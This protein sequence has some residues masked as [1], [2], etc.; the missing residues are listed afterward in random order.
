MTNKQQ[1]TVNPETPL[2]PEEEQN[3]RAAMEQADREA[4]IRES[5]H[6]PE[7]IPPNEAI[8]DTFVENIMA[9]ERHYEESRN[10]PPVTVGELLPDYKFQDPKQLSD[11]Q[12]QTAIS[13]FLKALADV[14]IDF[15]Q[16]RLMP[17]VEFYRWCRDVFMQTELDM[18]PKGGWRVGMIF[19]EL[20]PLSEDSISD[21]VKSAVDSLFNLEFPIGYHF[22]K[23]LVYA[24]Y[25]T[26]EMSG[27]AAGY[28]K[29]W[30]DAITQVEDYQYTPKY[31]EYLREDRTEARFHFEV[32]A[33]LLREDG[34]R[35]LTS[36][37]GVAMVTARDPYWDVMGLG[38]PGFSVGLD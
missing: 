33:T 18:V 38:F 22:P 2:N 3:Y 7:G 35:E 29:A 15:D 6:Y 28:V 30:R 19:S 34:S 31:A 26:G 13:E 27:S 17:P 16:P 23:E 37:P 21:C 4:K 25:E 12:A 5:I 1:Q 10:Q 14:S 20:E 32:E 11:A 8:T 24:D 36:G 9:I